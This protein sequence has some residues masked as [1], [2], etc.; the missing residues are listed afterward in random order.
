MPIAKTEFQ[1]PS[2]YTQIINSFLYLIL[3]FFYR[4]LF[5]ARFSA[6]F[7]IISTLVLQSF[8]IRIFSFAL[9]PYIVIVFIGY[10]EVHFCNSCICLK[11][12]LFPFLR[13]LP[14]GTQINRLQTAGLL[15]DT[16]HNNYSEFE[17]IFVLQALQ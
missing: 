13:N 11:F 10:Y 8:H 15:I 7:F 9:S 2:N 14:L 17:G 3:S 16:I 4:S 6:I 1:R 12:I 5:T